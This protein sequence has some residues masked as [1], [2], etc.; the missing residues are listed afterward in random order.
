ML[1]SILSVIA[2]ASAPMAV[3]AAGTLGM[4]LGNVKPDGSCKVQSDYE[5]DF[6]ALGGVTKLVRTYNSGGTCN[7][8]SEILGAAANKGFKVVLG[9]WYVDC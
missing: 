9:V 1:V 7:T 3:S 6:D 5:M 8:A 2:L 4:C